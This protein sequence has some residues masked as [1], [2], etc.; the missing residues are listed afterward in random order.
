VNEI[1]IEIDT[2]I[3]QRS[4]Q[5]WYERVE[6]ACCTFYLVRTS[7]AKCNLHSSNM[8]LNTK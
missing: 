8:Q 5:S 1:D 2:E 4:V 3:D 7:S 6:Q